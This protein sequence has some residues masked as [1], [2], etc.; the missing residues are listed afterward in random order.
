M[1][2]NQKTI[3]ENLASAYFNPFQLRYELKSTEQVLNELLPHLVIPGA[4]NAFETKLTALAKDHAESTHASFMEEF[5][6]LFDK[7]PADFA[8]SAKDYE[9]GNEPPAPESKIAGGVS[10]LRRGVGRLT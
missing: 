8:M 2:N 7:T 4:L 3:I 10:T 9:L 6:R 5:S 1:N